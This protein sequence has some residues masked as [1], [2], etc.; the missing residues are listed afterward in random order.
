MK[1]PQIHLGFSGICYEAPAK[2]YLSQNN[3]LCWR[4]ISWLRLGEQQRS[5]IFIS[6]L[7]REVRIKTL[8]LPFLYLNQSTY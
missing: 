5:T 8:N 6:T 3:N 1:F 4:Q 2:I 7:E